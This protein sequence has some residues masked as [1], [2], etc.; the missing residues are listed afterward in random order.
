M[1]SL[2]RCQVAVFG[3][4]DETPGE[5]LVGSISIFVQTAWS[6]GFFFR[7]VRPSVGL[8]GDFHMFRRV[9]GFCRLRASAAV[10]VR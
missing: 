3:R 1:D 8:Y 4:P 2:G 6:A 7:V 10:R 5:F 9:R